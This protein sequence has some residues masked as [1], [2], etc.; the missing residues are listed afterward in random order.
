MGIKL[1]KWIRERRK[2]RL[3]FSVA[4]SPF[5]LFLLGFG[6]LYWILLMFTTV[7]TVECAYAIIWISGWFDFASLFQLTAVAIGLC[8]ALWL[9]RVIFLRSLN[10]IETIVQFVFILGLVAVLIAQKAYLFPYGT[11]SDAQVETVVQAVWRS[12]LRLV[13]E[14]DIIADLTANWK[15]DYPPPPFASTPEPPWRHEPVNRRLPEI[16]EGKSSPTWKEYQRMFACYA[17]YHSAVADYERD[18]KIWEEYWEGFGDW[19]VLN[20]WR[21]DE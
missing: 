2:P 4:V 18:M 14:Y 21:Y 10:R 6:L 20:R 7:V 3:K 13:E 15:Y 16:F 11:P 17:D 19:Y 12:D 8:A 5:T 9:V 1:A